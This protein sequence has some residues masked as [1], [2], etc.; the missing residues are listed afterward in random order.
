MRLF[1]I[2]TLT[3][4]VSGQAFAALGDREDSI[5]SD[6]SKLRAASQNYRKHDLYSEHTLSGPMNTVTQFV[7]NDGLVFAVRWEGVTKP[8]LS[9]L[10]GSFYE[11]YNDINSQRARMSTRAPVEVKTS[12]IIVRKSGHM[13]AWRGFAYI[14]D[15][16]PAGVRLEDLQ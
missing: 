4:L 14:L 10:L 12:K 1:R 3:L 16:V 8:D 15:H 11:E 9:V 6:K 13:R 2:A 7:S 5:G